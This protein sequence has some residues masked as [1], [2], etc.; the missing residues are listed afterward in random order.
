M[1]KFEYRALTRQG[2]IVTNKIVETS[3][4]ACI[5]KIKRNGLIPISVKQAVGIEITSS[6]QDISKRK[7]IKTKEQIKQEQ[8]ISAM[9]SKRK[10]QND[11][12]YKKLNSTVNFSLGFNQKI[13]MRDLRIF[14]QDFYLLKKAGFNNIH[15]LTTIITNTENKSLKSILEDVLA[16]IEAGEYM[17]TTF[18][19]YPS[20]FPYIYI[21][22]IKVGELSGT[23]EESLEHAIKYLEDKDTLTTRIKRILIPN[24]AMFVGLIIL[25]FA[26]V[27]FGVPMVENLFEGMGSDHHIPQIT[28]ITAQVCKKILEYWKIEVLILA[29]ITGAFMYWKSTPLG[30]YRFDRFKYNMPIFGKLI[31]SLDFSRLI[32]GVYLN[33]KNGMRIQEAL[34]VS[35]NILNNTV[36]LSIV[37]TSINNIYN[38][39]SWIEPF[40][41]AH[42]SSS[43]MIEMMKIGMQTDLPEMLEKLLEYL[44]IDI[45]NT[46]EKI[47]RVLPEVTYSIVGV[48]IIFFTV[49][50]L[51]P[52]IQVYMG[53]WLFSAYGF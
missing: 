40:E 52:V 15:A 33:M 35:K 44:E 23:L 1:P 11:D 38:G 34:E 4:S 14:T 3:R 37:E 16:G 10:T 41:N 50:V 27:L 6:S 13:T 49:A 5:K 9:A 2:Q 18:E 19:Y 8:E 7:N 53:G 42:F 47:V 21:N 46:L 20:V 43:M 22:M 29:A 31:Y 24:I 39:Q 26:C 30:R 45:D 48:V 51:V 17:Y 25:T 28:I 32:Q 36:M 12:L